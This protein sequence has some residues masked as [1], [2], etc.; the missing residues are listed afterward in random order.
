MEDLRSAIQTGLT[1]SEAG[2]W[3][4]L[5]EVR[6]AMGTEG[7][8]HTDDA[9]RRL[10]GRPLEGTQHMWAGMRAKVQH[11]LSRCRT[12]LIRAGASQ[13]LRGLALLTQLNKLAQEGAM[14]QSVS[15][16]PNFDAE[17][18]AGVQ[19]GAAPLL[20]PVAIAA[21]RQRLRGKRQRRPSSGVAREKNRC[22]SEQQR[23]EQRLFVSMQPLR[24]ALVHDWQAA[25]LLL[26]NSRARLWIARAVAAA[27]PKAGR[28]AQ[29]AVLCS[30]GEGRGC[31]DSW[32]RQQPGCAS[33]HASIT[34]CL[35]VLPSHRLEW[36]RH[37][38]ERLARA[39][40]RAANSHSKPRPGTPDACDAHSARSFCKPELAASAT[41]S[42]GCKATK[43][44]GGSERA[45]LAS[46]DGSCSS[47]STACIQSNESNGTHHEWGE[48]VAKQA[49]DVLMR[50][51]LLHASAGQVENV[52]N[53]SDGPGPSRFLCTKT[54][55]SHSVEA[56]ACIAL[57]PPFAHTMD[58][59]KRASD[60]HA[61]I[62]AAVRLADGKRVFNLAGQCVRLPRHSAHSLS[63]RPV[64]APEPPAL[65]PRAVAPG[66]L[67]PRHS[68]TLHSSSS[69]LL[70]MN[71]VGSSPC[72]GAL[73][74]HTA[75]AP[76]C[77]VGMPLYHVR[78]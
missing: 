56:A 20:N 10:E 23:E 70:R 46:W 60:K 55:I 6:D 51:G 32:D 69:D 14:E 77:A 40:G 1:R 5:S 21:V 35:A 50:A 67:R 39:G 47:A 75:R 15:A 57:G 27:P 74:M 26:E 30:A 78:A 42:R 17:T 72:H 34:P 64:D 3:H 68:A 41:P 36:R 13:T 52:G 18:G 31:P 44:R 2:K 22:E 28:D 8:C 62:M 73:A 4:G 61:P 11:V 48:P 19:R 76:Q 37:G 29:I 58:P 7:Q 53:K 33:A 49:S 45:L 25:G 12:A 71:R 24:S 54:S 43:A 66:S 16:V 65:G 59:D 9:P 38:L 63:L